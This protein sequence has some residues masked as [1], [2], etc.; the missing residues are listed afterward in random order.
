MNFWEKLICKICPELTKRW[1]ETEKNIEQYIEMIIQKEII[2]H[3]NE[4]KIDRKKSQLELSQILSKIENSILQINETFNNVPYDIKKIRDEEYYMHEDIKKIRIELHNTYL[5]LEKYDIGFKD[6]CENINQS[7]RSIDEIYTDIR[8]LHTK[9]EDFLLK[10][11]NIKTNS[12]KNSEKLNNIIYRQGIAG[13]IENEIIWSQVFNNAIH[14]SIWL[15]NKTFYPGRW[16]AG[17]PMLYALY[18]ILN[19]VHPLKILELGLGQTTHM[20]TQYATW[21]NKCTHLVVEHDKSW[22]EFFCNDFSLAQNSQIM[23]LELEKTSFRGEEVLV[24]HNFKTVA[25][26]KYNLFV[27]DAPFGNDINNYSRIDILSILPKCL[28]DDFI[29]IIDDCNRKGELNMKN[30]LEILLLDNNIVYAEGKYSGVK[31]TFVITS[32][33]LKFLCSL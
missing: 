17:Y 9:T 1:T 24:Y 28:A 7:S 2:S 6:I 11:E 12:D 8:E 14:N 16:A 33:S 30:E 4:C 19:E 15:I 18:R 10:I 3:I 31:D 22:I 13:R 27:I 23:Q 29:I 5:K 25:N 32:E 26:D 21:N 20:V